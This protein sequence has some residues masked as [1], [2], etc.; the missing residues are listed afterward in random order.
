MQWRQGRGLR[1]GAF[2]CTRTTNHVW[3]FAFRF[4]EI[5]TGELLYK[6]LAVQMLGPEFNLEQHV[7]VFRAD[8]MGLGLGNLLGGSSLEKTCC[9]L[10]SH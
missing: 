3:I 8:H 6:V 7:H 5:G 4:I 1:T 9:L 10:N 2:S